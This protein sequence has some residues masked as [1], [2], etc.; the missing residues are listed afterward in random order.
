MAATLSK[1]RVE[2]LTRPAAADYLGLKP[3]TLAAWATLG[4]YGLR[5]I[6]CGRLVRYRRSDL[7]AFLASREATHTGEILA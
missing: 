2:L 1:D 4:R 3:Q 7:D 6:K 5:Y